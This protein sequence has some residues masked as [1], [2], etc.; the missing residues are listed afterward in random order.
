[1]IV[2][3]NFVQFRSSNIENGR[4]QSND[5]SCSLTMPVILNFSYVLFSNPVFTEMQRTANLF[6]SSRQRCSHAVTVP[7]RYIVLS[8][9]NTRCDCLSLFLLSY[10]EFYHRDCPAQA[11]LRCFANRGDYE[12]A[13]HPL[14]MIISSWNCCII[15][16][17]NRPQT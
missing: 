16:P 15:A 7:V 2:K 17:L 12:L 1:M 11:A 5:H 3:L 13:Y 14:P 9:T 10:F 6:K 4:G 8:Y